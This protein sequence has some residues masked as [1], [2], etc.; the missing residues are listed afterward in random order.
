MLMFHDGNVY[1]NLPR[2]RQQKSVGADTKLE[3]SFLP[4]PPEDS[5]IHS[6]PAVETIMLT[7]PR[8][9]STFLVVAF[10]TSSSW[11]AEKKNRFRRN[12]NQNGQGQQC[13]TITV[14]WLVKETFH[15]GA[16]KNVPPPPLSFFSR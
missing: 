10:L 7:A 2:L 6:K 3:L 16:L 5:F 13:E 1:E 8:L 14:T 9:P 15:N 4:S 12:L 11:G